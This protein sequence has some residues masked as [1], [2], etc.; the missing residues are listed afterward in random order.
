MGMGEGI[1]RVRIYPNELEA[2]LAE[3]V[4]QDA[5]IRAVV[6]PEFGG[7][8]LW[9]QNQFSAHGLWVLETQ[10]EEAEALLEGI[11]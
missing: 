11:C 9:G 6:R 10:V 8:G 3:G 4:L 2:R 7:Y 5:G 1:A